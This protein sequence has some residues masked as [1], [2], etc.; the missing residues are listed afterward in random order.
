MHPTVFGLIDSQSESSIRLGLQVIRAGNP[1]NVG[2]QIEEH[3]RSAGEILA[4]TFIDTVDP[5]RA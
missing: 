5:F 1:V 4:G 2:L 3:H